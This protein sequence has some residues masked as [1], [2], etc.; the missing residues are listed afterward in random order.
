MLMVANLANTKMMQKS[1][2]MTETLALGYSSESARWELSNEYQHDMVL[3]VFKNIGVLVLWWNE[4]LAM[5]G[6]VK[7][8][9]YVLRQCKENF[10]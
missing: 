1:W 4:V 9:F 6:L 10:R 7:K 5:E 3:M 8:L 2:K